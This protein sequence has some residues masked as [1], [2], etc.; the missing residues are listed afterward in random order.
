MLFLYN[1]LD[2]EPL[3]CR[4]SDQKANSYKRRIKLTGGSRA[5]VSVYADDTDIIAVQ[6]ALARY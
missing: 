3:F 2:L 5:S 1:I 4:L 6:K